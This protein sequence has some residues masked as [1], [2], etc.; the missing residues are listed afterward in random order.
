MKTHVDGIQSFDNYSI[1]T[2]IP[3]INRVSIDIT[4]ADTGDSGYIWSCLERWQESGK[5][6]LKFNCTDQE[7][8]ILGLADPE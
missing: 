7:A 2:G 3:V 8:F 5:I 1:T 6:K 4:A